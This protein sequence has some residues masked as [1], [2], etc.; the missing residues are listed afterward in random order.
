MQKVDLAVRLQIPSGLWLNG[1]GL[2]VELTGDVDMRQRG[3][4]PVL[5]GTLRANE[6][7]MEFQGRKLDIESGTVTFYGSREFNP[8]LNLLLVKE[9]NDTRAEVHITGTLEQPALALTSDPEMA[10]TDILSFIIFGTRRENLTEEQNKRLEERALATAEQFTATQLVQRLSREIG[11]DVLSYEQSRQDS[12]GRA[13]TIGKY[14]NP[15]LLVIYEQ[16][17]ENERGFEVRIQY[18]IGNGFKLETQGGRFEQ[19]GIAL[20]WGQDF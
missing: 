17:L 20:E 8:S 16:T 13:V 10:Q 19:S 5:V 15:N 2:E 12:L 7:K 1:R 14:I 18:W 9:E 3:G 4:T 11:L 6:G